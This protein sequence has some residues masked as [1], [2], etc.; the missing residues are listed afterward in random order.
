M[1]PEYI[2]TYIAQHD[3]VV[4]SRV[5]RLI[6]NLKLRSPCFFGELKLIGLNHFLAENY[7]AS[8]SMFIRH[9]GFWTIARLDTG[10]ALCLN[11]LD[12][13]VAEIDSGSIFGSKDGQGFVYEV[14]DGVG[15]KVK[16]TQDHVNSLI[17]K[18]YIS[19]LALFEAYQIPVSEV[20]HGAC[21]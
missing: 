17:S 16:C 14:H 4:P 1:T 13:T 18:S 6:S 11:T 8:P 12:G 19:I 3:V 21:E 9:F 20:F 7:H 2:F 15:S 5:G 10:C